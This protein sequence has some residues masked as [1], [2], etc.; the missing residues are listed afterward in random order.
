MAVE[1]PV[2]VHVTLPLMSAILRP[3]RARRNDL[4]NRA[5]LAD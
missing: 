3:M 5:T 2:A 4:R 1:N